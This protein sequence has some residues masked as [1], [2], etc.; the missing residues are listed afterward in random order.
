LRAYLRGQDSERLVEL[1]LG[2]ADVDWRLRERLLAEAAAAGGTDVDVEVWRGRLEAAFAPGD[3]VSYAEAASWVHDV[4]IAIE[5][6]A[7]LVDIGHAEAVVVL[8]EHAHRLADEAGDYVDDSDGWL[9]GISSDLGELHLR[10]CEAAVVDPVALAR[11]LVDLEL[12]SDLAAFRR[13]AARYAGV[14]GEAGLAEY[15]RLVE[16]RFE[17][18]PAGEERSI[19]FRLTQ[20]MTGVALASGDPDQLI[21]VKSRSFRTPDDYCEIVR[22]L[23][24]AGRDPE[25]VDW[26]GRGADA[27]LTGRG[28]LRRCV[29]CSQSC[30]AAAAGHRTR[31]RC[32]G[33]RLSRHRHCRPTAAC[34]TRSRPPASIP[35]PGATTRLRTCAAT[36]SRHRR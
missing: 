29:S 22:A 36:T 27:S 17:A 10:A 30:T 34:W 5:A 2:Q 35:A 13:A 9:T 25:A 15:R 24:R 12:S 21:A 20:A 1:L 26:A 3:F 16:P 33:Q 23:A 31:S 7:E 8:A 28:R 32:S 11:R 6:L 4:H 19:E 18:L 14:L